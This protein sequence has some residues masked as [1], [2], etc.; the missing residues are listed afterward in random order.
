MNSAPQVMKGQQNKSMHYFFFHMMK[1]LQ[2]ICETVCYFHGFQY[3]L[4]EIYKVNANHYQRRHLLQNDNNEDEITRSYRLV[5][6][7]YLVPVGMPST[8]IHFSWG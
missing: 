6:Y 5:D 7:E 8:S 3:L 2:K 4:T 1:F